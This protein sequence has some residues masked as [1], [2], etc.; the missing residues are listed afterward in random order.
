MPIARVSLFS[1]ILS[2]VAAAAVVQGQQPPVVAPP[3]PGATIPAPAP[4]DP[5]LRVTSDVGSSVTVDAVLLPRNVA[6]RIFGN[7]IARHYA[8]VQLTISNRNGSASLIL[9]SIL[10]DYSQ[11]LFSGNFKIDPSQS[12]NI[13]AFQQQNTQSQVASAEARLVRGDLL[14]AQPWT[15]RNWINRTA[16][17]LGTAASAFSFVTT[18]SNVLAGIA[19]YGNQIVPAL[20]IFWP[21][22]TQ[23]QIN[24]ISDFGFQDN[25]VIG[26]GASDT[27]VAFF[28]LDR[29]LTRPLQKVYFSN[30]AAFF[31]PTELLLDKKSSDLI[32]EPMRNAGVLTGTK[33]E[34]RTQIVNALMDYKQDQTM[35][36]CG[37][38]A[39]VA[40]QKQQQSTQ[41][42]VQDRTGT[43]AP[44]APA[45]PA[46]VVDCAREKL[47]VDTLDHL[48]LN[49]IRVVIGGVMSVDVNTVPA[50]LDSIAFV[51]EDKAAT[52]KT[53]ATVRTATISGRFLTDAMPVFIGADAASFDQIKPDLDRSSDTKLA[54]TYVLKS[55]IDPCTPLMVTVLKT[56]SDKT[57]VSSAPL[58]RGIVV[59]GAA[60][61]AA[62]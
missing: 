19:A 36:S 54:F 14:D 10:L 43:S 29:F 12:A 20:G 15:A 53:A 31:V 41:S 32:V 60:C 35:T 48:S 59:T 22:T 61:P 6:G 46:L 8:V 11:W 62:N 25:H 39:A 47:I 57:T 5:R 42:P 52:W 7:D 56:A 21:D 27:V 23:L 3:A 51:N 58:T 37:T 34:G 45:A 18:D 1:C 17:L 2:L 50:T 26:R 4:T 55:D 28:P 49:N 24:R 30:P 13:Q 38:K 9:H 40:L 16:A 44:T 33:K